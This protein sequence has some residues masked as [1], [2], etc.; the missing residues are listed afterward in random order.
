LTLILWCAIFDAEN[1]KNDMPQIKRRTVRKVYDRIDGMQT[2]AVSTRL[3]MDWYC[4]LL[5]VSHVSRRAP[6]T[7]LKM[8]V[9]KQLPIAERE[10]GIEFTGKPS[11]HN[12]R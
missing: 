12:I 4:R 3:N 2:V 8:F 9:E 7:V 10:Y 5:D 1:N 6:G 11:V